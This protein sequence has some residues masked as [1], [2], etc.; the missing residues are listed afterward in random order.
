LAEAIFLAQTETDLESNA[1][2]DCPGTDDISSC[3]HDCKQRIDKLYSVLEKK[4]QASQ[5]SPGSR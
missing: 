4:A 3:P 2:S 1:I 5:A